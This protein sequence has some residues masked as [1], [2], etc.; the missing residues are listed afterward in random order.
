MTSRAPVFLALSLLAGCGGGTP[1]PETPAPR[2]TE[3][4]FTAPLDTAA[5]WPRIASPG[6][7]ARS[8]VHN[9]LVD[10]APSLVT[11]AGLNTLDIPVQ[12]ETDELGRTTAFSGAVYNPQL[13]S[14]MSCLMQRFATRPVPQVPATQMLESAPGPITVR[15]TLR[16]RR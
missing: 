8:L 12:F 9:Y 4:E 13:V 5:P 15:A 3:L 16:L 1:P 14:T 11:C 6:R 10:I 7:D 2:H